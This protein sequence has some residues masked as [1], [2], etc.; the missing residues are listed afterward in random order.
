M[1]LY[2]D[3]D[4]RQGSFLDKMG[5]I[6]T[7]TGITWRRELKGN[8]IGICSGKSISYDRQ[9]LPDN[10][11]SVVVWSNPPTVTTTRVN[12]ISNNTNAALIGTTYSSANKPRINLA[13]N[14]YREFN[15][16]NNG[17]YHCYIFTIPGALQASISSSELYVDSIQTTVSA[18]DATGAATSRSA[19]TYVGGGNKTDNENVLRIKVYDHVLTAQERTKEQEEFES[20]QIIEKPIRNFI[21]PVA[22]DLSRLSHRMP[23]K[24]GSELLTNGTFAT[25]TGWTFDAGFS[26]SDYRLK[27]SNVA[28]TFKAYCT[29]QFNVIQNATYQVTYECTSYTS[30][31]FGFVIGTSGVS[32]SRTGIGIFTDIITA[33]TTTQTGVRSGGSLTAEFNNISI[34][35][36][37]GLLA[38]WSFIK[39]PNNTLS[40]TSG[41]NN[42]LTL[43]N[44][45]QGK[46]GLMFNGVNSVGS[47]TGSHGLVGDITI[48]CRVYAN[49]YGEGNTG[50]IFTNGQL[51]VILFNTNSNVILSRNNG[52]SSSQSATGSLGLKKYIDVV[53][54]STSSGVTNFYIDGVSSG[55][56]NQAAGTPAS[57]TAWYVGNRAANDRTFD[58]TIQDIQISNYIWDSKRIKNYHSQW[59]KPS[60]IETFQYPIGSF[61]N[62]WVRGTG[63][64][65]VQELSADVTSGTLKIK[66]GTRYL[67]C[68]TQGVFAIES[69]QSHGVWEID[70]YKNNNSEIVFYITSDNLS[71]YSSYA[72]ALGSDERISLYK[73]SSTGS[74]TYM[75]YSNSAYFLNDTWYRLRITRTTSGIFTLLIKGGSL[76]PTAG[77]DG[78]HLIS[79][80]GGLNTNPYTDT[81]YSSSNF[82]LLALR[83][84]DRIADIQLYDGIKQL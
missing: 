56:L 10:A 53:V 68:L 27:A 14:N 63:N 57:S 8:A 67:N 51:Y 6:G 46:D 23:E 62:K 22:S 48:A 41:N 13:T 52:E 66:K 30:G 31:T 16:T 72:I 75:C 59:V 19:F 61:P 55:N 37:T 7:P 40:D 12:I 58:G 25:S 77:Y 82:L 44:V 15:Y 4:F 21:L 78:Y 83:A 76:V 18:T 80:V 32:L 47:C 73:L 20:S 2:R 5:A 36:Y 54:T 1:A 60:L 29:S 64:F 9:L 74:I 39:N 49:S 50:Y 38:S 45:V 11:F 35:P 28:A 26:V 84:N 81:T 3:L 33:A 70:F 65:N 71:N 17:K 43:S 24:I 34:K 79:T 69:K 42:L